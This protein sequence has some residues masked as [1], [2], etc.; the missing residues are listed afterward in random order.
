VR[1]NFVVDTKFLLI[2]D[3]L[4]SDEVIRLLINQLLGFLA[5]NKF[6]L[7]LNPLLLDLG[8]LF[9][10][11]LDLLPEVFDLNLKGTAVLISITA[12][13]KLSTFSI[14]VVNTKSFLLDV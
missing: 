7:V 8:S 4:T 10:Y 11:F 12:T 3:T 13:S 9:F 2:K 5:L 14:E 1:L 6:D